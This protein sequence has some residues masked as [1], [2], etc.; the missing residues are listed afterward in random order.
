MKNRSLPKDNDIFPQ[1]SIWRELWAFVLLVL[2]RFGRDQGLRIAAALSYTSLL[3]LVPLG[4]IAFSVLRAFPVFDTVQSQIK[5][6]VFDNF[7]PASVTEV[8]FYLDQF[9]GK[10]AGLTT[11]GIVALALSA[12]MMLGTIETALN[13]IFQVRQTRPFVSRMMMFWAVITLGPLLLGGSLS[14]GTYLYALGT[15]LGAQWGAILGLG[16]ASGLAMVSARMVPML[17]AVAA[18]TVF[19]VIVPYQTVRLRHALAGGLA[20]GVLFGVLRWLF[21]LY[22]SAFPAYQTI[23]GALAVVPI[24][25][26]WMYFSWA[27]VLIGAE[28]AAVLPQWRQGREM[29]QDE[30]RPYDD[31]SAA[32]KLNVALVVVE[33]LWR[34]GRGEDVHS[35]LDGGLGE[36]VQTAVLQALRQA[37]IV[38]MSDQGRWF[39]ARDPDVLRIL[40]VAYGLGLAPNPEDLPNHEKFNAPRLAWQGRLQESLCRARDNGDQGTLKSL[41]EGE[42]HGSKGTF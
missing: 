40:D 18:F 32:Q 28:I 1:P 25:L 34:E 23:Y 35:A 11:L 31:L 37:K 42:A 2:R 24:F 16:S 10:T 21:A 27:V 12:I 7:L 8:Q 36:E 3:A 13:T 14:L 4:A 5:T 33:R 6:M 22:M 29:K 15:G 30:G 9:V 19:Y 17:M 26:I 38:V 41:F 20:A 39:L